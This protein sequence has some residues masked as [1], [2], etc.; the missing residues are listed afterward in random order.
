MGVLSPG[1]EMTTKKAR[2]ECA[3]NTEHFV[4]QPTLA[5]PE[6]RSPGK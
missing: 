4:D 2:T 6:V 3:Y 1:F 5:S